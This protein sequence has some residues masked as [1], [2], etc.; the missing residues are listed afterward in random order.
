ML[1]NVVSRAKETVSDLKTNAQKYRN[2][3]FLDAA[4]AA[5]AL[6][7]VADGS[8]DAEE[9]KKTIV[10]VQNHDALSIFDSAEVIRKFRDHLN[11][12]DP[13]NP[14]TDTDLAEISAF[15]TIGKVKKKDDQARMVLRLAIAIGGAD[16]EFD[17]KEKAMALKIARELGLDPAEF[18]LT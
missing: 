14:D 16:G 10:F 9:K 12:L 17:E 18:E 15:S 8:I 2:A 11:N 4:L 6:I 1:S 3:D 13:D 5:S 7:T